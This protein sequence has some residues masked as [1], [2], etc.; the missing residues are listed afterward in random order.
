[1]KPLSFFGTVGFE[2]ENMA[3]LLVIED[4][5]D[6]QVL[7]KD[8][9][10]PHEVTEALDGVAGLNAIR[11]NDF[12]LVILD[13]MLPG[14]TGQS[15][16]KTVRQ[17]SQVPVIVLTAIQD[18]DSVVQLLSAGAN[19]YLTKP[20][21]VEELKA[22]VGVQL[23]DHESIGGGAELRQGQ[24]VLNQA[25]HEVTLAGAPIEL[26]KKEFAVLAMLMQHPQ[27][28]F[29]KKAIYERIWQE[30]YLDAENTLNVHLSHLRTKLNA[31][32]N[33]TPYIVS[34]WGIGIRLK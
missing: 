28:V 18:K 17:H 10:A 33:E 6:I 31:R 2:G 22:R 26:P 24:L 29:S 32:D 30:P 23:R 19:D 7:L 27:Q 15:V 5:P 20:F 14:V 3:N 25:T 8:V 4:N 11:H 16:L 34:V 1:M 9:L 21:D 12:D 13:L